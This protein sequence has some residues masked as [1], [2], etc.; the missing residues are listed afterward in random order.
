MSKYS[1]L[2]VDD[3]EII[4]K[5]IGYDLENRGYDVTLAGSGEEAVGLVSKDLK[6]IQ[7][8]LVIT[9]L[10][11]EGIGGIKVLEEVKKASP[12]TMVIIL[13]GHGDLQS[14]ISAVKFNADDYILKPCKP[15]EMFFTVD[16]CFK[17]LEIQKKVKLYE[18]ILPVCCVCNK[19]RDDAT[20]EHGKGK[21][22]S[23]SAYMS[24]KAKID[25]SHGYCPDCFKESLK[26]I[27]EYKNSEVNK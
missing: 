22:L 24:E 16:Q 4:R 10:M 7:F 13:T 23:L 27:V 21:W 20:G 9:D 17:K 3:E 12:D 8:D 26:E 6:Y 2:L 14:A 25:V 11:M 18:K 5:T 15:E 19:I 1:I